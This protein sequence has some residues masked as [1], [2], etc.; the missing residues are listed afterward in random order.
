MHDNFLA[1]VLTHYT[2]EQ[3]LFLD[4]TA[5]DERAERSYVQPAQP[6]TP[7]LPLRKNEL[8]ARVV[9]REWGYALRGNEPLA[10]GGYSGRRERTSSVAT[11]D[12]K[13]FVSWYISDGTFDQERF[14]EA[15]ET[16]VVRSAPPAPLSPPRSEL[17]SP[18]NS[19]VLAR[20][21]RQLPNMNPFPGKRSVL[22]LDNASIHHTPRLVNMLVNHFC[23]VL[24]TPPYCFTLTPLDN[25]AFGCVKAYLQKEK[26]AGTMQQKMHAAFSNACSRRCARHF[27]RKC[28]Y[29]PIMK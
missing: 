28:G 2:A 29:G 16:V 3:L 8:I 15:V 10:S 18:P 12:V 25:S 4:E 27:F 9:R 20:V 14:L 26:L 17:P 22:V 13:G 19:S 11:F 1:H 5:K 6:P 7:I 24:F 21:L 23:V